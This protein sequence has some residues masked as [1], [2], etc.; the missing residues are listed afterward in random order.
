MFCEYWQKEEKTIISLPLEG[1]V[2]CEARRMRCRMRS[3]RQE[4]PWPNAAKSGYTSSVTAENG[5]WQLPLKGKPL[6]CFPTTKSKKQSKGDSL[7]AVLKEN[8]HTMPLYVILSAGRRVRPPT[9]VEVSPSEKRGETEEQR[10]DGIWLGVPVTFYKKCNIP[11]AS[12]RDFL[13]YPCGATHLAFA[14]SLRSTRKSSTPCF[15]LRSEWQADFLFSV[16]Q[17]FRDAEDVV[18]YEKSNISRVFRFVKCVNWFFAID[19]KTTFVGGDVL[20]APPLTSLC[21]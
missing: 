14:R 7:F 17:R 12:H 20:D 1:K 4:H 19:S 18:P 8:H 13:P 6:A 2:A 9:E 3:I 15:A 5:R 16:S 21:K 11:L 10:D